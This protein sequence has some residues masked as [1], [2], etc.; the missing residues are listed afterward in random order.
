LNFIKFHSISHYIEQIKLFGP[1][2]GTTTQLGEF[3]HQFFAKR[4]WKLTNRRDYTVQMTRYVE[5]KIK[6]RLLCMHLRAAEY[7]AADL[8]QNR[9]EQFNRKPRLWGSPIDSKGVSIDDMINGLAQYCPHV[10]VFKDVY[11]SSDY[12]NRTKLKLAKIHPYNSINIKHHPQ[13]TPNEKD[14]VRC[15]YNW[16]SKKKTYRN[17]I[18]IK[19]GDNNDDQLFAELLL[20]F[21]PSAT[22]DTLCFVHLL[23]RFEDELVVDSTEMLEYVRMNPRNIESFM[24]LD[25]NTINKAVHFIPNF[26]WN[27]VEKNK[28]ESAARDFPSSKTLFYIN[29]FLDCDSM[30]EFSVEIEGEEELDS[31]DDL[32]SF[33]D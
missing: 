31:D 21:R 18:S 29:R 11:N 19:Y 15:A 32:N 7:V 9:I 30:K 20:I 24:I 26:H 6:F 12:Y 8:E 14:I 5:R 27:E 16:G 1:P 2:R 25:A 10:R 3:A 28:W 22:K 33:S 4:P 17:F 13:A 23:R